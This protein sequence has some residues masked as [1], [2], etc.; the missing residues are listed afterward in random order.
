MICT[1]CL[2]ADANQN[3]RGTCNC[4]FC[5]ATTPKNIANDALQVFNKRLEVNDPEAFFNMGC[6]YSKGVDVAKDVS[7]GWEHYIRGAELGSAMASYALAN[8]YDIG[9]V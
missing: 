7:K 5:R 2:Y 8:A 9:T 1:G 4:P 3:R 6:L